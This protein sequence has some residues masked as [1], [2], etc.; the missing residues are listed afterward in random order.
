[1][2]TCKKSNLKIAYIVHSADPM[3]GFP[4]HA[5]LAIRGLKELGHTVDF[6]LLKYGE[7][8]REKS[9]DVRFL[10]KQG[11]HVNL[12]RGCGTGL[13]YEPEAGWVEGFV[14]FKTKEQKLRLKEKLE[15][16][17]AVFWHTPFW[18]KQKEI[19]TDTDWPE[20]LNLSNPVNIGMVHDANLRGNSAWQYHISKYFD[21]LITVHP[22]SYNSCSVLPV[23]RVMI[24]NPQDL[25]T[26]N[27]DKTNFDN[28]KKT[29]I[30]F[31][32]QN[33]KA[34]KHVDDLIRAI[35]YLRDD[36]F[37]VLG[38]S[39]IEKRYMEAKFKPKDKYM[40]NRSS[41]PDCLEENIGK[42]ILPLA[43][44]TGRVEDV[45]WVNQQERDI[46]FGDTAFFID[47]A[48]YK[49]NKTLGSHF[50]RTLIESI[51]HGI[52]PIARNLGL[53]NNEEGNGEVFQA[54]INYWMI[55]YDATP[56][57]FAESINEL[58]DI[59]REKYDEIVHNN[60][61]LLSLFEYKYIAQ[62]YER[63][64][65]GEE[66]GIYGGYETGEPTREFIAKADAQWFGTGDKK[67]FAFKHE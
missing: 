37:V 3:G 24:F 33:W 23:P 36:T 43:K 27:F 9:G 44:S 1:M 22:A 56:K 7:H 35:P 67:T 41:D 13:L 18:F 66:C 32:L 39:G 16:Y 55:P 59:S 14:G 25:S 64:I 21:R 53:S 47:T 17:D 4:Q 52:V 26:V 57:Q 6:F 19:L 58:M 31:S 48:W 11:K 30:I 10:I 49:V 65:R 5:E 15:G 34:S 12:E 38:G 62:E 46:I 51:M 40:V 29:G 20:L 42:Q 8:F 28:I 60:Y 61:E 63:L 2:K 54:G 50:S 45:F